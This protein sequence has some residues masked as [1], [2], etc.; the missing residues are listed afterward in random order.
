[1]KRLYAVAAIANLS[2][3]GSVFARPM[4]ATLNLAERVPVSQLAAD[5][6]NP[7]SER[8]G[9][10]YTP[11]EIRTLSAPTDS[12]YDSLLATLRAEGFSIIYESNSHLV[13]RIAADHTVFEKVFS[14]QIQFSGTQ[15]QFHMNSVSP[16]IPQYLSAIKTISGFNN[17]HKFKPLYT[18]LDSSDNDSDAQ[19]GILPS[20][21]KTAYGLDAI[22]DDGFTG[23][24]QHIAIATYMDFMLEDVQQYYTNVGLSPTPQIDKVNFNGKAAYDSGSALETELDAEFSGMIAPGANIHVFTSA[25][26]SDQAEVDLFTAILDDNRAKVVN[27]SWGSC[28][29]NVDAEHRKAMD[30]VFARAVAQGVNLMI[31]SGDSGSDGCEDGSV[32]GEWPATHPNVVAVGGTT[33]TINDDGSG[34]EQAWSG[35]GGGVSA[36]YK[37]PHWQK[38][39]QSPFIKR[40]FPDI[41][42]NA[43]PASGEAVWAR[44][45]S[46]GSPSWQVIGGTS[47]AA[48]Q[49]TGFLTLVNEARASEGRRALGFLNPIL[50]PVKNKAKM[51][52][53]I[54]SGSNGAYKATRGWNAV[55]GWGSMKGADLLEYLLSH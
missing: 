18:K 41:A 5:V 42:F 45:D 39:F 15:A 19:P 13:L 28:E 10:F 17:T 9:I 22:Y 44:S 26:N 54:T 29:R 21:I 1:M 20:Q 48:P 38:N 40:S 24:G 16:R 7:D 27:Y 30:P 36:F 31:A 33:L 6:S 3:A 55:T 46:T 12:S 25:E 8:Y 34:S 14:T 43:D 4:T 52:S 32:A 2:I 53:D 47:M 23:Q 11:E 50:Y 35:S 49:W 37:L 51:L